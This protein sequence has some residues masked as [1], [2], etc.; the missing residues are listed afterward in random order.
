MRIAAVGQ[1]EIGDQSRE[2]RRDHGGRR[3]TGNGEPPDR[4]VPKPHRHREQHDRSILTVLECDRISIESD[5]RDRRCEQQRGFA[6]GGH[7]KPAVS[8]RSR[9]PTAEVTADYR[10]AHECGQRRDAAGDRYARR[11]N[12]G[13]REE[14]DVARHVGREDLAEC[15][16]ADGVD[17]PADC[18]QREESDR[19]AIGE[20]RTARGPRTHGRS[21]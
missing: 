17:D 9:D 5:H 10:T 20:H 18:R 7:A 1:S 15:Q 2:G 6:C 14:Y 21:V 13:K 12:G 4:G 19:E 8:S 16:E 3:E 11:S